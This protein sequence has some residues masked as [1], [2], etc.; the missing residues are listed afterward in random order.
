[1]CVFVYVCSAED[2]DLQVATKFTLYSQAP[3]IRETTSSTELSIFTL[4][5]TLLFSC[6]RMCVCLC[7]L[8]GVVLVCFNWF[9]LSQAVRCC[10]RLFMQI[11]LPFAGFSD[12]LYWKC[13]MLFMCY[14]S[15]PS[16][17][18]Y[19]LFANL[20]RVYIKCFIIKKT[21]TLIT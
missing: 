20:K 8:E 10:Q 6:E 5:W 14:E 2:D 18:V 21:D 1:M 7:V 9:L 12:L 17:L 16:K 3:V 19:K 11:S 15:Q 13:H 4:G